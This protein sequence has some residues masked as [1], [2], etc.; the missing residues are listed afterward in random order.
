MRQCAPHHRLLCQTI[1]RGQAI[2]AA[3]LIHRAAEQGGQ[4]AIPIVLRIGQ[5]FQN[6][7]AHPFATHIAVTGGIK[8]LAPAIRRQHAGLRQ[9]NTPFRV[10]DQVHTSHN[11]QTGF[12]ATQAVQR[13]MQCHQRG[14]TGGIERHAGA[15]QIQQ[16]GNAARR[17][18]VRIA[19][20]GPGVDAIPFLHLVALVIVTG[21]ADEHPG[22]AA[23]QT[24]RGNP[25]MFQRFPHGFQQQALL[26]VHAR[27]FARRNAEEIGIEAIDILDEAAAAAYHVSRCAGLCRIQRITRPALRRHR[28]DRDLRLLQQA[29]E[30]CRPVCAG[31]TAAETDHRHF[32]HRRGRQLV[33]I[34]VTWFLLC[35]AQPV[36]QTV[37]AGMVEQ[38]RC[39]QR[40][41]QVR[42]QLGTQTHQ[43]CRIQAKGGKTFVAIQLG[44]RQAGMG[45]QACAQPLRQSGAL[46]ACGCDT[47]RRVLR[48]VWRC[49]VSARFGHR[50]CH[51]FCHRCC[52]RFCH[53][54]APPFRQQGQITIQPRTFAGA[55]LD[56]AAG[57][58]RHIAVA[59][60]RQ[61]IQFHAMP[62]GQHA[63]QAAHQWRQFGSVE[64]AGFDAQQ[65]HQ[66]FFPFG[67]DRK[68][69]ALRDPK[70]GQF[71][72]RVALDILRVMVAATDDD[73]I[74]QAASADH[75]ALIQQTQITGAQPV[76]IF[77]TAIGR[78]DAGAEGGFR[79]GL[80][81]PVTVRHAGAAHPDFAQ[82]VRCAA[83][84]CLRIDNRHLHIR[85]RDTTAEQGARRLFCAGMRNPSLFQGLYLQRK[86]TGTVL[87]G[88]GADLEHAFGQTITAA[89]CT[90]AQAIR[91]EL[92]NQLAHGVVADRLCAVDRHLQR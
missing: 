50:C 83:L 40:L 86:R 82:L 37:D 88:T 59:A 87:R 43:R 24:G 32:L 29:P 67:F 69:R 84:Q 77:Q 14:R 63:A 3:I 34:A 66:P 51:R 12:P 42:R 71:R 58:A 72:R 73:Q 38:I 54:A 27:R 20:C 18:A 4:Y 41:L 92:C 15:V 75:F 61:R 1:R 16:I 65:Q 2:A 21:N 30:R 49:A 90:G 31:E 76:T 57:G 48:S 19:G 81:P 91:R 60:Q 6:H 55:A 26:R 47:L 7:H 22:I 11:R 85:L 78:H 10:Q 70:S 64:T 17:H 45:G 74:L 56:F 9:C 44:L 23:G 89:R 79:I 46:R 53:R 35:P 36:Q 39:L 68:R 33:A 13:L 25:G 52:H 5:P 8:S 62:F 28:A 80:A